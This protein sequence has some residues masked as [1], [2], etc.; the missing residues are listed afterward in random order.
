ME[1]SIETKKIFH[2][3]QELKTSKNI[4]ILKFIAR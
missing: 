2:I 3:F 4:F 1:I